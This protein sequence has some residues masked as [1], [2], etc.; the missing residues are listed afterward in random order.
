MIRAR[1]TVHLPGMNTIN[2]DLDDPNE[3][4]AAAVALC[5]GVL[6][7]GLLAAPF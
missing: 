5:A 6:V 2:V 4:V 7:A 1:R 3:R